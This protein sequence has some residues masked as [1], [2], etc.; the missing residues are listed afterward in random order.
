[1]IQ[2]Y[3][4]AQP[5]HNLHLHSVTPHNALGRSRMLSETW[6]APTVRLPPLTCSMSTT[7]ISAAPI[8]PAW[9]HSIRLD[10]DPGPSVP[11]VGGVNQGLD[12]GVSSP[13]CYIAKSCLFYLA[14][15]CMRL[16]NC[17]TRPLI[18]STCPASS[19]HVPWLSVHKRGSWRRVARFVRAQRSTYNNN[20]GGLLL[21]AL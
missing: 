5:R 13:V 3:I 8:T 20:R 18:L 15:S 21:P 19:C 2:I 4:G 9:T 6:P 11:H 7:H 10:L 17:R 14:K 1:M 12:H 16:S